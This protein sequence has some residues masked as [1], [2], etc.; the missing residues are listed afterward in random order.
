MAASPPLSYI[1][2]AIAL[3]VNGISDDDVIY[4][5]DGKAVPEGD[6]KGRTPDRINGISVSQSGEKAIIRI[7]LKK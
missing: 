7:T 1:L 2:P 4:E 3:V 5:L 6:L